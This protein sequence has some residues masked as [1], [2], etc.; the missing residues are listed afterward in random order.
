M[1]R[2]ASAVLRA[3][4]KPSSASSVL[5][6]KML[7]ASSANISN[8]EN[9]FLLPESA[10][11]SSEHSLNSTKCSLEMSQLRYKLKKSLSSGKIS[12]GKDSANSSNS[13]SSST[14]NK[15]ADVSTASSTRFT[16]PRLRKSVSMRSIPVKQSVRIVK[17][18]ML[19]K[20]CNPFVA[21]N[22][23]YD[24]QWVEK[25]IA[26]FSRWLNFIL[27]PPE[28]E[29]V[30]SPSKLEI[31][32][33]W[34]A[35]VRKGGDMDQRAPTKEVLSLKAYTARGRLN[36]LRRTACKHYQKPEMVHVV[37]KLE[38]AIDKKLIVMRN[39][40]QVHM[41]VGLKQELLQL[42]LCYNP[43]WL[44]LGLE[45]VF[46]ELILLSSNSDITG[47]TQY[48]IYRLLSNAEIQRRFAH[49]SVPHCYRK[50]YEEAVKAFL[51]KKFLILVLFLDSA[52]TAK[53]IDHDPCLFRLDSP[54]KCSKDLL[55][56]FARS[57]LSGIG[58]VTKHLGYLGYAI[59]HQQTTLDEFDYAVTN[60]PTDLRCGVRLTRVS[61]IIS[62]VPVGT[63]SRSL[64]VPAVSRLQKVHNMGVAY[65]QL[66]QCVTAVK[67]EEEFPAADIVAGH[68]ENTLGLLWTII[69]NVH[70][71]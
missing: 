65:G 31:G 52:K 55:L 22:M 47:I 13:N 54:Y 62:K 35:A 63:L 14:T 69:F 30:K 60:L 42:L 68:R 21:D 6:N 45:T 11:V 19:V 10:A 3:P 58:D 29:D 7:S 2:S 37:A 33:L 43:L 34:A 66:Q 50:G 24:S 71:S 59:T 23:Y 56:E 12:S 38:V 36:R 32:G 70:V 27:T 25:Q 67:L 17:M 18:P 15:L 41:D 4:A 28:E 5:I 48:I 16:R 49:P 8:N 44:R 26:G 57:F 53:L 1:R 46:A 51:L 9:T 20:N 40:R 64:R 39:D 61:E